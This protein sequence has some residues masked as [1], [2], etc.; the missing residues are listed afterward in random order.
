[1]SFKILKRI[2]SQNG[3]TFFIGSHLSKEVQNKSYDY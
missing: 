3:Q 2:F 1:M